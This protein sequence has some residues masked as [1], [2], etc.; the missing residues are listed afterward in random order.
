M[1]LNG[2]DD[3]D[4]QD[5][6]NNFSIISF[7][8]ENKEFHD[9]VDYALEKIY[10]L[11]DSNKPT[12]ESD[13]KEKENEKKEVFIIDSFNN[14][15]KYIIPNNV[16]EDEDEDM[17]NEEEE[18]KKSLPNKTESEKPLTNKTE[19]EIILT[20]KTENEK[21]ISEKTENEKFLSQKTQRTKPK[22][23]NKCSDENIRRNC[24]HMV[25]ESLLEF[26]NKKIRIYYN[27]NIGKG[28]C[29]KQLQDL[30]QKQKSEPNIEFNKQFLKKNIGE[31]FSEMSGRYTNYSQKH[32][33]NL[34]Q[35]LLNDKDININTYFNKLFNLT[36]MQCFA[37]FRG[38]EYHEELN[39]MRLLSEELESYTDEDDEYI[40]NL[41][42]YFSKYEE[43]I[44]NKKSRKSKKSKE[45]N[46]TEK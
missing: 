24:K 26:I 13:D 21:L 40:G 31:I 22:K 43:I 11:S 15:Q 3:F 45:L 36:F 25:I 2:N 8:E 34:I 29:T 4:Y 10:L 9:E 1:S 44:N 14:E 37:H 35:S 46:S 32:N 23:K 5:N 27:N 41:K 12:D 18:I 17:K 28:I 30:N 38:T 20:N 33:Y 6:N 39:G 42:Y 16:D 7:E 19:N